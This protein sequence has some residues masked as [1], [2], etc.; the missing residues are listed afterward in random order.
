MEDE[1]WG[2]YNAPGNGMVTA[3]PQAKGLDL[4]TALLERHEPDLVMTHVLFDRNPEHGQTGDLV[5][6]AFK[7]ATAGGA[8][9]G[10]VWM[11][12]GRRLQYLDRVRIDPDISV[13]VTD[14]QPLNW[15]ALLRHRSQNTQNLT[16]LQPQPGRRRYEHFMV[17]LDNTKRR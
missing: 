2:A 15:Q 4:M 16:G 14:S 6:R 11:A 9:L 5:Y 10:Q 8:R 1:E 7:R 13:D 3:A 12:V 17:V